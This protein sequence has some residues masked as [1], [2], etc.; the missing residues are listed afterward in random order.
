MNIEIYLH[1]IQGW[2]KDVIIIITIYA[3]AKTLDTALGPPYQNLGFMDALKEEKKNCFI[4]SF[5]CF[6]PEAASFP[7]GP[8][9]P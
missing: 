4:R 3:H 8:P 6:E 2:Q 9:L 1:C 7:L 5:S